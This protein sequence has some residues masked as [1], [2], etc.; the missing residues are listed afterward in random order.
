MKTYSKI[1][2]IISSVYLLFGCQQNNP[3]P[4]T[5]SYFLNATINGN[6]YSRNEVNGFQYT[7]QQGCVNGKTYEMANV[8]QIDVASYFLDLN[9]HHYQ[10]YSD[11]LVSVPGSHTLYND[12]FNTSSTCNLDLIINLDDKQ[13]SGT[14]QI[15]TLQTNSL[16]NNI[17]SIVKVSETSTDVK[18]DIEGNFSCNFKN[19][20]NV[21][22]PVNGNYKTWINVLK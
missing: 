6:S 5:S 16:T 13:F 18:Y 14:S 15:C 19:T 11:F 10:N 22:I 8:S 17:T 3:Q 4:N 21:S 20:N 2:L 7:N 12:P 1:F 9:I